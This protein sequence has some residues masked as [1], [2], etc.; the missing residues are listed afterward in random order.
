MLKGISPLLSA[1]VLHLLA[2]MGHGD[3]LAIVDANHPANTVA[4]AEPAGTLIRLPG[5]SMEEFISALLTVFPID[6]YVPDPIRC[7]APVE[8]DDPNP[9]VQVAIREIL[10]Q[11]VPE[12]PALAPVERFEFYEAGKRACG[13]IQL[14]D[15]RP[16]GCFL[17][18]KG[19]LSP[20]PG[21]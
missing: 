14:G 10:A 16:Y 18:R 2:S 6:S 9:E 21:N 13:V 7:M 20:A 15:A 12:S 4:R 11:A 5:V 19:V 8:G 1:D 17:F 3:D